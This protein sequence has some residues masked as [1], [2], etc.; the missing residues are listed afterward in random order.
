M[1]AHPT[2]H[3]ASERVF[4]DTKVRQNDG[5]LR[6]SLDSIDEAFFQMGAVRDS[7][8]RIIDFE[9]L[10]CNRAALALL[11]RRHEDMIGRRLL[12]LFPSHRTNGLFDKYVQVAESGEP[13]RYEF[14]FDDGGVAGEFE[15]IVSATNDGYVLAGHDIS[16]RKRLERELAAVTN[17]LQ[18]ALTTRV[19]IEQA[20][21]YL[22]RATGTDP[23]TAFQS[24]RRYARDNKIKVH[25]VCREVLAGNLPD[26][27]DVPSS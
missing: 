23:E 8:G 26:V 14:A 25:D 20:K 13:L 2:N 21:G 24:I 6:S 3:S 12:A 5:P 1:T 9:Y 22:A 4:E 17:Q 18:A 16:D 10:Y 19:V 15:I 11:S 7:A 27:T